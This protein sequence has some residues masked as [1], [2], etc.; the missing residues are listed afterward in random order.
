MEVK[1]GSKMLNLLKDDSRILMDALKSLHQD[2][3]DQPPTTLA[4]APAYIDGTMMFK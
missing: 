4:E 3:Q 2:Y 1:V